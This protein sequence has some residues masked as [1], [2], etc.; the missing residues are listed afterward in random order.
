MFCPSFLCLAHPSELNPEI[1]EEMARLRN[2]NI[3]LKAFADA[4]EDDAV[5]MLNERLDD[6]Q[7]LSNRYKDQYL[8]TKSELERTEQKLHESQEQVAHLN[9]QVKD[10]NGRL[11][12]LGHDLDDCKMQLS[13]TQDDLSRTTTLLDESAMREESLRD[14]VERL[15]KEANDANGLAAHRL[16]L[17]ESTNAELEETVASLMTTQEQEQ[18]LQKEVSQWAD[19]TSAAETALSDCENQL[20]E[21]KATLDETNKTLDAALEREAS[22]KDTVADLESTNQELEDKIHEGIRSMQ[23]AVLA[24]ENELNETKHIL[25]EKARTELDQVKESL[26]A[27]QENERAVFQQEIEAASKK[28]TQL[29]ETAAKDIAQ[30]EEQY[31]NDLQ[32]ATDQGRQEQD[33]LREQYEQQIANVEKT[34]AD[35]REKLI[36]KGKGMLRESKARAK[37]KLTNTEEQLQAAEDEL[38]N[39]RQIAEAFEMK[40]KKQIRDYKKKLSVA[41]SRVDELSTANESLDD[42]IRDLERTRFKLQEEN[43]RFRRQLGGRFGADGKVQNQLETLLKE[44]DVVMEENRGLKKEIEKIGKPQLD[45]LSSISE[46]SEFEVKQSSYTR[47][48]VSG[49]TLSQIRQEYDEEIEALMDEKRELVMKQTAAM[50]D[51]QKAEQRAWESDKQV[52]NLKEELTSLRLKLQRIQQTSESSSELYHDTMT[53]LDDDA[54]KENPRVHEQRSFEPKPQ[55][56]SMLTDDVESTEQSQPASEMLLDL[57]YSDEKARPLSESTNDARDIHESSKPKIDAYDFPPVNEVKKRASPANKKGLLK[58]IPSLMETAMS[59]SQNA[60]PED[61][62]P[63]CKQS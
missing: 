34:A 18:Q 63:E 10:L 59:S 61:G 8:S 33:A 6:T 31:K 26:N 58:P 38:V 11:E 46:A 36:E 48:G 16:E 29:E 50:T 14:N 27:V 20:A 7:R 52:Q 53:S 42:Q 5:Q 21:T 43:E 25:E 35:E 55:A 1:M 32:Q 2:E 57:S 51:V 3:H 24:A 45:G 28:Y 62:Q 15:T 44:F 9:D 40:A 13:R 4:R 22:L 17:L 47:G 19:K 60:V 56:T 54:T 37:E 49:S 30:L 23:E 12:K 41:S 39:L